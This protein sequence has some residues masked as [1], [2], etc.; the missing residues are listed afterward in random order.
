MRCPRDWAR[1]LSG[2][3]VT[4][5][6]L[7]ATGTGIYWQVPWTVLDDAGIEVELYHVQH[8]KQLRGRKTEVEYS[9]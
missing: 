1:W 4:V 6:R 3:L 8:V 7:P 9:C 5:S 2:C